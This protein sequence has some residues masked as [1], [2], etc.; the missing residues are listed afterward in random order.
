MMVIDTI[1]EEQ[2]KYQKIKE[3][4]NNIGFEIIG[5]KPINNDIIYLIRIKK[6]ST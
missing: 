5:T 6:S 1:R 4:L 2:E 3:I